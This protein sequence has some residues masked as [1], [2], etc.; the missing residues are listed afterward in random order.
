MRVSDE[1][2]SSSKGGT[3]TKV[4][5]K[6]RKELEKRRTS[7]A[8]RSKEKLTVSEKNGE[9]VEGKS[10]TEGKGNDLRKREETFLECNE[11]RVKRMNECAES[12]GEEVLG[13]EGEPVSETGYGSSTFFGI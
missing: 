11:V 1:A 2:D 12:L 10:M 5:A 13:Y 3:G 7:R 9:M 4:I 8:A 6:M